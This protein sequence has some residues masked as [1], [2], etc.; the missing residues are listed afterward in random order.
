L[1][2][3][4]LKKSP[5]LPLRLL[6][7][8][9]TAGIGVPDTI[10]STVHARAFKDN[11]GAFLLSTAQRITNRTKYYAVKWHHFWGH[12]KDGHHTKGLVCE[13]FERIRKLNQGW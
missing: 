10:C 1:G 12:V 6:L 2:T 11:Q 7:L 8:K 13:V 3:L 5:L 9:V 4:V